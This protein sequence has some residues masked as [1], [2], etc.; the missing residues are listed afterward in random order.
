MPELTT[1]K[2]THT[3]NRTKTASGAF[4]SLLTQHSELSSK[5]IAPLLAQHKGSSFYETGC[6]LELFAR[7]N[8]TFTMDP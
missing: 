4:Q 2:K 5:H 6:A 3:H 7:D 1:T 8:L